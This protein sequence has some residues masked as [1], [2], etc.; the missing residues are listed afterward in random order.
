M[1]TICCSPCN[2]ILLIHYVLCTRRTTKMW[3]LSQKSWLMKGSSSLKVACK[4]QND[5]REKAMDTSTKNPSLRWAVHREE[6]TE[7]ISNPQLKNPL[8][9]W[10]YL[11]SSTT[12]TSAWAVI[13]AL[14]CA[15]VGSSTF[16]SPL[17]ELTTW[18]RKTD[19]DKHHGSI[20]LLPAPEWVTKGD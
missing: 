11:A 10:T 12:S 1:A 5:Q 17:V 14:E 15:P 8:E 20:N 13:G 19:C 6:E 4:K 9:I 2:I 7:K 16:S 3:L 18:N